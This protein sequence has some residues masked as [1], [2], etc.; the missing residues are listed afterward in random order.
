MSR[1]SFTQFFEI[2]LDVVSHMIVPMRSCQGMEFVSAI[3]SKT[4]MA[5]LIYDKLLPLLSVSSDTLSIEH[6]VSV[7]VAGP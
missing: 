4:Y 3:I 5:S 1:Y 2:P 6:V 7:S